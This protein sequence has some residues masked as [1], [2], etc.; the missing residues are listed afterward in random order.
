MQINFK[1]YDCIFKLILELAENLPEYDP[2]LDA[3]MEIISSKQ[4]EAKNNHS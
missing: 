3:M 4:K 1:C 2:K